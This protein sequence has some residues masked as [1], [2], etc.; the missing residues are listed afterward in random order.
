LRGLVYYGWLV[1]GLVGAMVIARWLAVRATWWA[2]SGANAIEA[3]LPMWIQPRGLI[4][5]VLAVGVVEVRGA[6]FDFLTQIAFAVVL[7]TNIL[8]VIGSLR[9]SRIASRMAAAPALAAPPLPERAK[10]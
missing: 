2:W 10:A 8:V 6:S 5:V 9:A 1:C 3:E 7:V 4:T